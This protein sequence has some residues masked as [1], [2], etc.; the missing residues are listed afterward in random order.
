MNRFSRV[1]EETINNFMSIYNA[2]IS[3]LPIKFEFV[4]DSK[5][6]NAIKISKLPEDIAFLLEKELK[7]TMNEE[8][9]SVYDDESI[10]ILIE[11]EI[12]KITMNNET[13]KIKLVK[14]DIN[15]F[16]S[17]V[18]KWGFDKVAR[19]NK[20]EELYQQQKSDDS[21]DFII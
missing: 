3:L 18:G 14:T 4:N 16:S 9:L 7:V 19:A 11:Q 8:L 12:D 13:G 5:S 20:V 2:K 17:L 6:K 15:T 21:G 1:S 10:A